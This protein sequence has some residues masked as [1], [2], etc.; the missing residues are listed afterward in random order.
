MLGLA[1][2]YRIDIIVETIA[3]VSEF[4]WN[5]FVAYMEFD[6]KLEFNVADIGLPGGVQILEDAKAHPTNKDI[7]KRFGGSTDIR[8][9]WPITDNDEDDDSMKR[10]G[11]SGTMRGVRAK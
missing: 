10:H 3:Q 1:R 9:P 5:A 4:R 11:S 8:T 6:T 7:I 2:L